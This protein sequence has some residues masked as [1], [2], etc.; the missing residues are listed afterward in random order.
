[1]QSL[2]FISG[3]AYSSSIMCLSAQSIVLSFNTAPL[4][5][6]LNAY[7]GILTIAAFVPIIQKD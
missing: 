2:D 4:P 3:H 6:P 7:T 1:M 5:L